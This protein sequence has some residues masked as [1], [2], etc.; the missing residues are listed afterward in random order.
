MPSTRNIHIRA[1]ALVAPLLM[2]TACS[3]TPNGPEQVSTPQTAHPIHIKK[4]DSTISLN[5]PAGA[6]KMSSADADLIGQYAYSYQVRGHGP[7][8]VKTPSGS[9]N[10]GAAR[11]AARQI[12]AKLGEN[13]IPQ[14]DVKIVS[15]QAETGSNAPVVISH[16]RFTAL[17]SS[18]ENAWSS[19]TVK[20]HSN[21]M[22]AGYGCATQNN[23]A[24]LVSDPLDLARMRPVGPGDAARRDTV[25]DKY[26]QGVDTS[27]KRSRDERVNVT[28]D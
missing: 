13:G 24:A 9:A 17:S 28:S 27:A 23:I 3:F 8:V 4:V 16:D 6:Y 26:R 2:V 21:S 7:V 14:K 11:A 18:C 19:D 25:I 5:V 1:I 10:A 22:S 12:V 20:D 15:Y